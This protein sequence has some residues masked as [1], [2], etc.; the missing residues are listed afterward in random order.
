MKA[1][2]KKVS[3]F[4]S[5]Y[6]E[7]KFCFLNCVHAPNSF[8]FPSKRCQ[9]YIRNTQKKHR[10]KKTRCAKQTAK[11][12]ASLLSS[13]FMP[14]F[15]SS[16]H[17]CFSCFNSRANASD[18]KW[19]LIPW[20]EIKKEKPSKKN[21]NHFLS[22]QK[23][24]ELNVNPRFD[25]IHLSRPYTSSTAKCTLKMHENG[26]LNDFAYQFFVFRRRKEVNEIFGSCSSIF[27]L[28]LRQVTIFPTELDE[29]EALLSG[30]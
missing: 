23:E 8:S 6:N 1:Q 9:L 27:C 14:S 7:F 28:S 21:N 5:C 30:S 2:N 15:F 16:S 13:T 22:F 24:I 19:L 12:Y 3:Q 29:L 17:T 11:K 25:F 10:P 18:C 26:H 20:K 4:L